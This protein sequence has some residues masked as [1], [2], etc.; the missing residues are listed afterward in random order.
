MTTLVSPNILQYV[1]ANYNNALATSA[2]T[3]LPINFILAQTGVE[4][5]WGSSG[6]NN[7]GGISPGGS[8]ISYSSEQAGWQ[9]YASLLSSAPYAGA[10]SVATQ[11]STAI[12]A[13]LAN[14]GYNTVNPNY[15]NL[16][17]SS[18]NSVDA[19]LGQLGLS[20]GIASGGMNAIPS[21]IGTSATTGI[22]GSNPLNPANWFNT[23]NQWFSSI[24]PDI[25]FVIIGIVL[26]IGAMLLFANRNLGGSTNPVIN[27]L[28]AKSSGGGSRRSGGGSAATETP[29]VEEVA[30]AAA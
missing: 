2:A 29:A 21:T 4:S 18:S 26:L 25:A 20:G 5:G 6:L 13:Y 24:G 7:P 17:G 12:A 14:A 3:G 1:Q 28:T 10:S 8:P 15:A 19:A 27:F 30:A 16:V 9:A 22:S 23:L 11:G